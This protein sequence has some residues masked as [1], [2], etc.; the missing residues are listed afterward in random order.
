MQVS[1]ATLSDDSKPSALWPGA[2][3]SMYVCGGAGVGRGRGAETWRKTYSDQC[4][5]EERLGSGVSCVCATVCHSLCLSIGGSV[6]THV[7]MSHDGCAQ[8]NG[9]V[10][11]VKPLHKPPRLGKRANRV[12]RVHPLFNIIHCLRCRVTAPL[13]ARRGLGS[14]LSASPL[15]E[16]KRSA[17]HMAPERTVFSDSYDRNI[18]RFRAVSH[19]RELSSAATARSPHGSPRR[20]ARSNSRPHTA[21]TNAPRSTL[22]A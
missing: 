9:H 4:T 16:T 7:H 17:A 11:C 8:T 13:V 14:S 3:L 12:S 22:T 10:S 2:S 20:R 6:P 1:S 5:L 15:G 21:T 18:Q 19:T